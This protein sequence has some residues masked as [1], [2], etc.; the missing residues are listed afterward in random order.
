MDTFTKH[1]YKRTRNLQNWERTTGAGSKKDYGFLQR[2]CDRPASLRSFISEEREGGQGRTKPSFAPLSHRNELPIIC[3]IALQKKNK[4]GVVRNSATTQRRTMPTKTTPKVWRPTG[5][6]RALLRD[7][8]VKGRVC[9]FAAGQCWTAPS[10]PWHRTGRSRN[11]VVESMSVWSWA[12]SQT[13]SGRRSRMERVVE[14][15]CA[16]QPTGT[17]APAACTE[18]PNFNSWLPQLKPLRWKGM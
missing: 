2:S 17:R 12:R 1:N 7:A 3:R 15:L 5:C 14:D 13:P 6:N 9:A 18:D 4:P 16:G 11:S 8:V 10:R